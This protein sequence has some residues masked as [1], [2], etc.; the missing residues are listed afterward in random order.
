MESGNICQLPPTIGLLGT[1]GRPNIFEL[2][3]EIN[4]HAEI[5]ALKRNREIVIGQ[6]GDRMS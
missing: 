1:R 2:T 4:G 3:R 6:I 5:L